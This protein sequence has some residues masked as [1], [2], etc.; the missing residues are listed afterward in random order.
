MNKVFETLHQVINQFNTL[1]VVQK[2]GLYANPSPLLLAELETVIEKLPSRGTL[3]DIGT[4]AGIIP[5]TLHRLGYNVTTIDQP[6]DGKPSRGLDRAKKSGINTIMAIVGK[7][8]INLPSN[9]ADVIFVGDVIEHLPDSPRPFMAEIA[10][11]L[12]PRG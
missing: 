11:L 10:S 6:M 5:H 4:A 12:K 2:E 7:D 9:T 8:A 3:I 1:E